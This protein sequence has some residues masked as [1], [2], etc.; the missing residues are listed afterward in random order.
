[1]NACPNECI[2]WPTHI[3]KCH[4]S[5]A[6]THQQMSWKQ[7]GKDFLYLC[8]KRG[9]GCKRFR[10]EGQI[11]CLAYHHIIWRSWLLAGQCPQVW[12]GTAAAG[13]E[14]GRYLYIWTHIYTSNTVC[15]GNKD[16]CKYTFTSAIHS[17]Q[18]MKIP[19]H[20]HLHHQYGVHR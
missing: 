17:A 7:C 8:F 3:D 13:C 12:P 19:A 16:T 14:A 1:M 9:G 5:N 2:S 4:G 6:N 20:T 18:V 10:L 15:T 11:F